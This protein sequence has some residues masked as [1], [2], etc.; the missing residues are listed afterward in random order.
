[1]GTCA[2]THEAINVYIENILLSLPIHRWKHVQN[3]KASLFCKLIMRMVS[4]IP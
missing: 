3:Q 2:V 1:M 4:Y